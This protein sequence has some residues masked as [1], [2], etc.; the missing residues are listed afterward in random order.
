MRQSKALAILKSGK[1]VFLT[2][3]AGAGKTYVLNRFIDYLKE[4]KIPVAITAYTG[5]AA[6]HMNGM[7]IHS[8]S[9]IGVKDTLGPKDLQSMKAKKYI[10]SKLEKVQVLIIDEISMLHKQQLELVNMV[11][12]FFKQNEQ[13]FGGVQM[14]FCGDFFQLPPV[15][16]PGEENRDK[17]A[18]MSQAWLEASPTICYINEQHR[19]SDNQLNQILN[20]IR[21][22]NAS[23]STMDSLTSAMKNNPKELGLIT[24]LYTHNADVDRINQE[25]LLRLN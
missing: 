18:F 19:Q 23:Q 22:G 15:G 25:H 2:G 14:V 6:T 5:I 24:R 20:E 13:A 1:N 21:E 8:W 16:K 11:M 10:K 4:K 3:S 17:F 12:K 7:T 9:G